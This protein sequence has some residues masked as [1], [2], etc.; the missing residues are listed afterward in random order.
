LFLA[1][2]VLWLC[3]VFPE[4]GPVEECPPLLVHVELCLAEARL[5]KDGAIAIAANAT[6]MTIAAVSFWLFM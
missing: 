3:S 2:Q 4:Q 1:E 6:T 5:I